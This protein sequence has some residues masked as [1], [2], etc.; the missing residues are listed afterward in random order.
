[1]HETLCLPPCPDTVTV[2]DHGVPLSVTFEACR[3]YHGEDSIGGLALGYRLL[4]WALPQLADA[5]LERGEISFATAFPG[6][7]LKDAVEMVTRAVSRGMLRVLSSAPAL[8]PEGVYGRMYFEVSARG[9][10]IRV[11]LAPGAVSEAFVQTGRLVKAGSTDPA[12]HV[13]WAQLKRELGCAVMLAEAGKL[14][15]PIAPE[16]PLE[17]F[18]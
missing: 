6:P 16:C 9:R 7:G 3:L 4:A 14:F 12:V 13:R 8:A 11:T 17:T 15:V 18:S 10:T 1:M 2:L 5:P